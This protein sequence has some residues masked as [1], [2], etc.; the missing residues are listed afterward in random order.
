MAG[1][2]EVV[3]GTQ[4]DAAN[5]MKYTKPKPMGNQGGK[6]V[7]ILN[8]KVNKQTKVNTPL[9]TTWGSNEW[10][11]DS[12]GPSK[13][14][15]SLQ[16]PKD[17]YS[18]PSQEKFLEN[19]KAFEAKLKADAII[20]SKEWFGKNIT[21]PDVIDALY[22]PMLRYPKKKDH[23]GDPTGDLDLDRPPTL[24][25]KIPYWEGKFN[26]KVFNDK[27]ARLYPLVDDDGDEIDDDEQPSPLTFIAKGAKV[28]LQIV[29]GGIWF[30]G[31]K[32]GTN[33]KL[34]ELVVKPKEVQSQECS[35]TLDEEDMATL[36]NQP[37][38]V[39]EDDN[40][41]TVQDSANA[42]MNTVSTDVA[43]SDDDTIV[44]QTSDE[45]TETAVPTE[46]A[47]PIAKKKRVVKKKK[48]S[49]EED[50]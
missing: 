19:M 44:A 24:K 7:G 11:S 4:Y 25:I 40:E 45:P 5:M 16:F 42:I 38:S 35:V 14:D 30:A 33:W 41:D 13:Y 37:T 23:N 15:M 9:M 10:V 2:G 3:Q 43:D 6:Q 27:K 12:G 17:E 26:F 8:A 32:F 21:S 49:E 22:T 1:A 29:N 46:T 50:E 18:T 20:N 47:A 31:G 36:K 48:S 28:A 39:A 34:R